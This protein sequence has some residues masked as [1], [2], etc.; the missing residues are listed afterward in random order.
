M[1]F[2]A[3]QCASRSDIVFAPIDQLMGSVR[4]DAFFLAPFG[5]PVFLSKMAMMT[6]ALWICDSQTEDPI[7]ASA[8]IHQNRTA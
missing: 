1:T 3:S 7:R 5:W 2:I 8:T 6:I 4:H